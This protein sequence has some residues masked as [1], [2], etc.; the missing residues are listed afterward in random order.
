MMM[1]DLELTD[2]RRHFSNIK[3]ATKISCFFFH[4]TIELH[5]NVVD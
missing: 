2:V 3:I 1:Y 4:Q 5:F